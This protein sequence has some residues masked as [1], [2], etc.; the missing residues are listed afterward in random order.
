MSSTR[1]ASLDWTSC[2]NGAFLCVLPEPLKAARSQTPLA[3]WLWR[4]RAGGSGCCRKLQEPNM[5]KLTDTQL[6]VLSEAAARND[7]TA[8]IPEGLNKAAAIKVAASLVSRKLMREVRS[9]PDMPVWREDEEGR[10]TSLIITRE[11]REAIGIENNDNDNDSWKEATTV[12]EDRRRAGQ[13]SS[14]QHRSTTVDEPRSGSKQALIVKML[15]RKAGATLEALVDATGWLPHTTRAALT[16]LRKRGYTVLLE[17]QD[18]RPSLHRIAF[19][20]DRKAA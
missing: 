7:G 13:Q 5:A 2:R 11:G 18:G 17:R 1:E 9:K 20:H 8:I 15:S 12:K 6:I 10:G 16:G 4:G 14:S 3:I 19:S